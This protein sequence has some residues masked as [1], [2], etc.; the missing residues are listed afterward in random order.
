MLARW[1][2]LERVRCAIGEDG[3]GTGFAGGAAVA[4]DRVRLATGAVGDGVAGVGDGTTLGAARWCGSTLGADGWGGFLTSLGDVSTLGEGL[5]V[6]GTGVGVVG[7]TGTGVTAVG[8][9]EGTVGEV[10]L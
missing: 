2:R 1:E 6:C 9:C 10:G 3:G 7:S 4:L 8:T 5:S